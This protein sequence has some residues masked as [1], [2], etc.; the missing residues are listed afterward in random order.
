MAAITYRDQAVGV[1]FTKPL[2]IF[3]MMDLCSKI[4]TEL[5]KARSALKSEISLLLPF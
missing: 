3:N 1:F 5:T 4:T 2:R